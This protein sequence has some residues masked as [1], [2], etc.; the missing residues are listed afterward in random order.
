[1][2]IVDQQTLFPGDDFPSRFAPIQ[3]VAGDWF[4]IGSNANQQI[5]DVSS[6]GDQFIDFNHIGGQ[7]VSGTDIVLTTERNRQNKGVQTDVN[8]FETEA[9]AGLNDP[10]GPANIAT[11]GFQWEV[12]TAS[13]NPT[14]PYKT[15]INYDIRDLTVL[16]KIR[17]GIPIEDPR[18]Q[19]LAEREFPT[20]EFTLREREALNIAPERPPIIQPTLEDKIVIEEETVAQTLDLT[21]SNPNGIVDERVERANGLPQDVLYLTGIAGNWQENATETEDITIRIENDQRKF[22]EI[23]TLGLP[24]ASGTTDNESFPPYVADLHIPFTERMV[25]SLETSQ[26]I[27]NIDVRV[28]FARVDRTLVEKALYD[29]N[30]EIVGPSELTSPSRRSNIKQQKRDLFDQIQA[31]IRAGLP[32]D[33]ERRQAARAEA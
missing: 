24:G 7:Q 33:I 2:A 28:N 27:N 1:M 19:E 13:T 5:L 10:V 3:V 29:L 16:D 8:R 20:Q 9:L 15:F 30:D 14:N 21:S 22:M 26:D 31:K 17:L 32:V 23:K 11:D 4:D 18:E 12:Q 25:V 6:F